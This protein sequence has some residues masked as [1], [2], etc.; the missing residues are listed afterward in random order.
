[1]FL[2]G[3]KLGKFILRRLLQAIPILIFISI[4]SFLLMK[5][6]PGDPIRAFVTPKM[7]QNDVIRIRHNL[8]LDKPVLVQYFYWLGN[9]LKGSLGYSLANSRPVS[10]QIVER[11]PATL[12]L[13]GTSLLI[14]LILSIPLGLLSAAHKNKFVDKLL[15]LISY[16]GI[17][18]PSFWFAMTLIYIFSFK[19]HLLPSIGMH[20]IG[21]NSI[22]DVIKHGIMPCIVLSF[23]NFSVLVRYIRS[24]TMGQLREDYVLT[25]YSKG[26]SKKQV[27][28]HHVLKNSILPVIT[29]LGMSLPDLISGAFITETIFGWPGMGRLGITSI[30]SYDYPVIMAITMFSSLM[31]IIGNLLADIAYGYADPRIRDL[32]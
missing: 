19:L 7:S 1:M 25:G 21:I 5:A 15:T 28:Y 22:G 14:S 32:R 13:M 9:T 26:L 30:F 16:I 2:G 18:I 12:G 23:S 20:T 4:V 11:L 3:L 6:A 24:S 27:L 10:N 31:L 17:S 29:I 8:G